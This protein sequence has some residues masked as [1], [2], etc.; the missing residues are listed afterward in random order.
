[1]SP[2]AFIKRFH[3]DFYIAKNF[4]VHPTSS[5]G[6]KHFL[7]TDPVFVPEIQNVLPDFDSEGLLFEWINDWEV[8]ESAPGVQVDHVKVEPVNAETVKAH[9]KPKKRSSSE[10]QQSTFATVPEGTKPKKR[11]RTR[12]S[13][14][15]NTFLSFVKKFQDGTIDCTGI[16]SKPCYEAWLKTRK[17]VPLRPEETFRKSILSHITC[18]DG[19]SQPFPAEVEKALLKLLR[20][21]G[22]VWPCFRDKKDNKGMLLKIGIKGLRCQGYHETKYKQEAPQFC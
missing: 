15:L 22:E 18:T 10:L 11:R 4:M 19:G 8:E 6:E 3:P 9:V 14:S 20:R 17:N 5:T 1:M 2:C 16:I 7:K 13:T 12:M 21:G